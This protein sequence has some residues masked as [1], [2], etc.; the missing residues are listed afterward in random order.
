MGFPR[1]PTSPGNQNISVILPRPAL[2]HGYF[3]QPDVA[4]RQ[5]ASCFLAALAGSQ[6]F[7]VLGTAF[8]GCVSDWCKPRGGFSA[9]PPA[10]WNT[11]KSL[12]EHEF[13]WSHLG[14]VVSHSPG[15]CGSACIVFQ[16]NSSRCTETADFSSLSLPVGVKSQ[17]SVAAPLRSPVLTG[18]LSRWCP[19]TGL[20]VPAPWLAPSPFPVLALL[21]VA[22]SRCHRGHR[23]TS[24]FSPRRFLYGDTV[25]SSKQA[26]SQSSS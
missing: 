9:F 13:S 14:W 23:T 22:P 5:R 12:V 7:E 3:C 16:G 20:A 6:S 11:T 10:F 18:S 25:H 8:C 21:S 19:R 15:V 24:A 1:S 4:L 2:V 17:L 26:A